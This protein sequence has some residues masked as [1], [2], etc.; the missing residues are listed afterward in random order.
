MSSRTGVY[1]S[2]CKYF[3]IDD[4]GAHCTALK[5]GSC[6]TGCKFFKD[7]EDPRNNAL[8]ELHERWQLLYNSNAHTKV[9]TKGSI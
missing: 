5:D 2:T 9:S 3:R 4:I 7:R 6:C 8:T 1:K